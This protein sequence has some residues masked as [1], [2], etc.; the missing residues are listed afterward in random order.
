MNI[1]APLLNYVNTQ[2]NEVHKILQYYEGKDK[3]T[4]ELHFEMKTMYENLDKFD[5]CTWHKH[6][7]QY[8][9]DTL[10]WS[11]GLLSYGT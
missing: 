7:K 2:N 8:F 11:Y 9:N 10:M 4:F 3:Y 1:S 6:K 5:F